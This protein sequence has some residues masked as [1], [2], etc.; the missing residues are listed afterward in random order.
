MKQQFG[1]AYQTGAVILAQLDH[2]AAK[3][4]ESSLGI[5]RSLAEAWVARRPHESAHSCYGRVRLLIGFSSYLVDL[6]IDSFIPKPPAY[7]PPTF[8]PYIYAPQEMRALFRACDQLRLCLLHT[9]SSLMSMPTLIR[10]LYATGIRIGEALNLK[11]QDVNLKEHYLRV[12]DSKNS[13]ERLIPISDSLGSVCRQYLDYRRYLPLKREPT[14]F[15][16]NLNGG[17]CSG[18]S[19]RHWFKEC[20]SQAGIPYTARIHDLR[21]TFA[22]TSL[23]TMA[24]AGIDLYVS[25][26]ILS[27][28]LGHQSLE[29]TNHYVRLTSQ[30]YP[31]LIREIDM[32]C[33]DVFPKH[34]S[35][36]AD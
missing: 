29:S 34:Y 6:G 36:E 10:L 13:K 19:V 12:K 27:H 9:D 33:L 21:H 16:V 26:P 35:H 17:K 8:I 2:L 32:I 1:F 24:E 22:V 15:F 5:T 25:L 31:G 18:N 4:G 30:M 23:A 3:R 7:P 11:N 28:Y 20:R 14:Y